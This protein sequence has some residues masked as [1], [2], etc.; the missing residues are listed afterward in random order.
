MKIGTPENYL[1]YSTSLV[2]KHEYI[3]WKG[4]VHLLDDVQ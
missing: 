2:N 4:S 3:M 1:P